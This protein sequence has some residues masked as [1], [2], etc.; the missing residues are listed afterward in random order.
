VAREVEWT[1][2]NL[3]VGSRW[4][5]AG[6]KQLVGDALSVAAGLVD[7]DGA[8]VADWRRRK[9]DELHGGTVKLSRGS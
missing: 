8:P 4:P 1:K 9:V 7:G 3:G 6:R 5:G 2:A